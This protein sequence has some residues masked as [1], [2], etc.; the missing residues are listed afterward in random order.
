MLSDSDSAK[1]DNGV[2]P[3]DSKLLLRWTQFGVEFLLSVIGIPTAAFDLE[4]NTPL[5][6]GFFDVYPI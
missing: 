4:G 5:T 6:E 1:W 2:L 3:T